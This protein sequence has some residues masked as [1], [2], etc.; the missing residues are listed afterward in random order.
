MPYTYTTPSL[1]THSIESLLNYTIVRDR[2]MSGNKKIVSKF[3]MFLFILAD[4][5]AATAIQF[6]MSKLK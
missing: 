4:R 5:I 1:L 6:F 2:I 3:S